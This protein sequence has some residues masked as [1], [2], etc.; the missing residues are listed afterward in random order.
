[1][2]VFGHLIEFYFIKQNVSIFKYNLSYF[3]KY[4]IFYFAPGDNIKQEKTVQQLHLQNL[5]GT[6]ALKTD[7]R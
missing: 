6:S 1:M 3:K 7:P 5:I 2:V 4:P